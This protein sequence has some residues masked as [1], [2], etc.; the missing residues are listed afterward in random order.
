LYIGHSRAH[1]HINK[2]KT[3]FKKVASQHGIKSP[4]F[5]ESVIKNEEDLQNE[6][7]KIYG[8]VGI[9]AVIKSNSSNSKI[10]NYISNNILD[11]QNHLK[12]INKNSK[13]VLAEKVLQGSIYKVFVYSYKNIIHT[14]IF[15]EKEIEHKKIS[16]TK[17][18]ILS[19]IK[20]LANKLYHFSCFKHHVEFDF[21]VND[22][23][24]YFLD[25]DINPTINQEKYKYAFLKSGKT[26]EEYIL[27]T[28]SF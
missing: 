26:L 20:F 15:V 22:S 14:H 6:A 24:I 21:L 25:I 16:K 11:I 27:E 28:V 7:L 18:E 13:S 8:L 3:N 19:E 9:P 2:N 10:E 4:Y 12:K 1:L 17:Q 23:G 5:Y